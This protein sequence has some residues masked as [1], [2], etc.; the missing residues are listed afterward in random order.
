MEE[1][2]KDGEVKIEPIEP[3][4]EISLEELAPAFVLPAKMRAGKNSYRC[5]QNPFLIFWQ[6]A[7][8]MVQSRTGSGKTGAYILPIMQKIDL[9]QN[10]AQA[11]V[12]VPTREL[13][14][15]V[16]REAELL[17]QGS[18]LRT[19]VVYGGV[20]YNCATGSISRRRPACCRHAGTHSRS[21]A[22]KYFVAGSPE[23]TDF[24]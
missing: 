4:S 18:N 2:N 20:G 16:S 10:A 22:E 21:S 5:R 7:T 14:M 8:M 13:A 23:N 9:N 19:A 11:L 1:I 15:Q 3:L 12:L 24:R 6:D 17:A